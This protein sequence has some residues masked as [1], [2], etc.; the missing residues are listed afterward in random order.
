[1]VKVKITKIW[2]NDKTRTDDPDMMLETTSLPPDQEIFDELDASDKA[3][4]RKS[5]WYEWKL[6][7]KGAVCR[8]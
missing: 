3:D 8:Q 1:M 4:G 7:T 6:P 5:T 2:W